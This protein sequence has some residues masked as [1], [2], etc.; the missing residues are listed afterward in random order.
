MERRAQLLQYTSVDREFFEPY[1]SRII[2]EDDFVAPAKR[3]LPTHWTVHRSGIWMHCRPA[4][5]VLPMQGWK[6]HVSSIAATAHIVLSIAAATLAASG[7]A[8]KFAADRVMLSAINGKR[9]PRGGSGKFITVYPRDVDDFRQVIADLHAAL[10]G[11]VGPYVLTDRRYDD[12]RVLYYRYGGIVSDFRISPGGRHEW[13]LRRPDDRV[14]ADDRSPRFRLP[15]W[16]RDPFGTDAPAA[17]AS[18]VLLGGGRYRVYEALAFS[19]AGG[20]YL[21]DDLDEGRRVVIKEARPFVGAGETAKESL[22]KEFRLLRCLAPLRIAPMP[23]AHFEEWEHSFLVE[24][25]LRGDTLRLWLGR[26]YPWLKTRATR[27]DVARFLIDVVTVY[28]RIADAVE[29]VHAVGVSLGDLSFHNIIVGADDDVRLIDLEAAV[30]EGMDAPIGLRTPGF[31]SGNP[32]SRDH[33]GARK[34]DS[35]AFGANLLAAMIPINAMLPLDRAAAMRFACR[36][37]EDMGY[38]AAVTDVIARLLDTSG[39]RRPS[40]PEVMAALRLSLA[41]VETGSEPVP[42]RLAAVPRLPDHADA[43]FGY[44]TAQATRARPDRFVPAAPE[45][46]ESHP[47]GVAH[48]AAGVLHA[49]LRGGREPPAGLR[50]YLLAGLDAST[51]RGVSL[52]S[53]DAGI[54]WVL[55]D[56]GEAERAATLIRS[57]PLDDGIRHA[58]GLHEGLAGWG[59]AR[60]KAWHETADADFLKAARQAGDELLIA[61]IAGDDDTL[62]WP[63][64]GQQPV[65]LAYGAAG[66]ALFLLHLHVATGEPR[67]LSGATAAL[68][69]DLAQRRDNA[70]GAATWPMSV[71]PFP[72]VPYLRQGTAGIVAVVARFLACTGEVR[73]R[74]VLLDSE[75]DLLRIHAI[76]PGLFDGLAGI[77]ETLLDLAQFL[78]ERANL[79]REGALR[80]ARGIEP[81]LIPRKEGLAVPGTELLRI[82]CDLATGGVG[83]GSFFD[84]L[85][86]AAPAAFMLDEHLPTPIRQSRNFASTR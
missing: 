35:Y 19:S 11:Y 62:R 60:I 20:V 10:S 32:P 46:F 47:W 40:P 41:E 73:Y 6:I 12:S 38:P 22:R 18:P 1:A 17:P 63:D 45:V 74:D 52:M 78:P 71:G 5:A 28:S 21:A 57:G 56:A 53:G 82:S 59:L 37:S 86:R 27:D 66:I 55:F 65:G 30:E 49:Y 69:F 7:T 14:E 44:V 54:A 68:A 51:P 75:G 4:N 36:M 83:V 43:L 76:S 67:F 72:S 25:Y 48:G 85:G 42:H 70:D 61:A 79:Y 80:V 84:R 64:G 2:R 34:E 16:L 58:P 13:L 26:R 33:A 15:D 50:D 77:G 23:I 29:R 39:S 31:A 8:F 81:F 3:V 24:E 9:W